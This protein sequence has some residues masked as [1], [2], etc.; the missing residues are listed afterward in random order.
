MAVLV[1]PTIAYGNGKGKGKY[2][3]GKNGAASGSTACGMRYGMKLDK[4]LGGQEPISEIS[5]KDI[6]LK[7]LGPLQATDKR[8]I[9]S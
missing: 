9:L 4:A 7:W 8:G 3:L 1:V 5:A 6:C 2:H